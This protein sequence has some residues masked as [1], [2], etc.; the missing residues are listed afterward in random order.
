MKTILIRTGI[1]FF[2]AILSFSAVFA[3]SKAEITHVD[4]YQDGQN[5][6]IVYDIINFKPDE[7]FDI[8]VKIN[9][10]SGGTLNPITITGDIGSGVKGD[11]GLRIIWNMGADNVQLNEEISVEVLGKSSLAG[12]K[13]PAEVR[14]DPTPVKTTEPKVSGA[15]KVSV[16]GCMAL[17]A[18]L[19]GLGNTVAKGG[20]AYWLI[21]VAGYGM[22]AGAIIMNG[23]AYNNF[24]DYKKEGDPATRDD[25][26]SKA[27]S[28][29]S[30][31]NV[32]GIL[33]INVWALDIL[34]TGL[35]AGKVNRQYRNSNLSMNCYYNPV[36]QAPMIGI[37]Y[38]F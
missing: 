8:W 2:L 30:L 35:Q 21:G 34:W 38:R 7:T 11:K 19:P 5:L 4:F 3:Q 9:K 12:A 26:Y 18:L 31:S 27:E 22:V 17:S 29:R 16:P 24:E 1:I 36:H 28:Q 6:V 25:L 32:L 20:G 14:K 13:P 33:A 37:R 23:S 15:K 10:A